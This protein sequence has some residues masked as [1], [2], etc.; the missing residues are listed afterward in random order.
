MKGNLWCEI[1]NL[2]GGHWTV[3]KTGWNALNGKCFEIKS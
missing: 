3:G 1:V 2:A